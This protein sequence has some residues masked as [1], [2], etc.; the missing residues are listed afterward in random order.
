[1]VGDVPLT[2]ITKAYGRAFRD[3]L[4]KVPKALPD[5]LRQQRL[6]DL[7]K[8]DLGQ[9]PTRSAQAINK[10]LSLLAG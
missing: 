9:F 1:M 5:R 10:T 8:Q 7:L 2:T 6:P 3:A 4:A